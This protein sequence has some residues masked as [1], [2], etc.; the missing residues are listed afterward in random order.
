VLFRRKTFDTVFIFLF[1]TSIADATTYNCSYVS[2]PGTTAV[3]LNGINNAGIAVGFYDANGQHNGLMYDTGTGAITTIDY[4]GAFGTQLFS[5][6]SNNVIVGTWTNSNGTGFFT[7]N[8]GM[9]A[10]IPVRLRYV[11]LGVYGINDSG[12][13]SAAAYLADGSTI[14]PTYGIFSPDG[15]FSPV[16][17][18]HFGQAA[19]Q[20]PGGLNNSSEMLEVVQQFGSSALGKTTGIVAA[21]SYLNLPT[22]AYGLNNA[23]IVI[24]YN[25]TPFPYRDFTFDS[26]AGT[27]SELLC[28]ASG[29]GQQ[30]FYG[31][32]DSGVLV[33]A[34]VATPLPG[35]AQFS[36]STTSI[37]FPPT[38]VG[39]TSAPISVTITNTGDA[40]LDMEQSGG[41]ISLSNIFKTDTGC[42]PASG[43]TTSL[44]PGAS[45]T[46]N[47][48][49]TPSG[50]G[51]QTGTAIFYN[52]S[53]TP[54]T[55]NL[56]VTGTVPPPSCQVSST[57][58][59][60]ASLTMQDT[61]SG[62]SS[63]S[64]FSQSNAAVNIPSFA[65]GATSPVTA[66]ASQT[67]L[68]Q[69]GQVTLKAVNVAGGST[70]CSASFH[71]SSGPPSWTGLGGSVT[72]RIS[73]IGN[74]DGTLQ[75]FTR[76]ADNA[77][78]TVAQSSPD[79]PWGTWQNIGGVLTSAPA[80]AKNGHGLLE[81]FVAGSDN[82]LWE[83]SQSAPNGPFDKW[84]GLGQNLTS[85]PA[86]AA[87]ADGT[88]Q[89]FAAGSDHTLWT[90]HETS[91]GG[92]W[93]GW[94]SLG[95]AMLKSPAAITNTDGSVEA[96]VIGTDNTVWHIWQTSPGGAWSSWEGLG[97]SIA[98]SPIAV[99]NG[100]SG[101]VDVFAL[102]TDSAIWS[103]AHPSG[104]GW[105]GWTSLGGRL[106]ADPAAIFDADG[107][108]EVFGRG[109]DNGL[110]RTTGTGWSPLGGVLA[111]GP[112]AA[113]NQ[114][115]R[116]AVFVEGSDT[117]VWTI[118]QPSAGSWDQ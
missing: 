5:I 8:S 10:P 98:G 100:G 79:G 83:A 15:S 63:I 52:S 109:G 74:S 19:A 62:L 46:M 38:P 54:S 65:S 96:F 22:F 77:L 107:T 45:C 53:G 44:D 70:M 84:Q 93:A 118:E 28:P 80:V 105:S 26:N 56:S 66:T 89:V 51:Q 72:G 47:M 33:G 50:Q 81:V 14:L 64:L 75:A 104:A 59:G 113:I 117:T 35:Q 9:F 21:V 1:A 82:S 114:N 78:W 110:W 116:V 68:S 97:G 11:V 49:A 102:G 17:G 60:Q 71:S 42:L 86:V 37:T 3:Q 61:N 85:D 32:N 34:A 92:P 91:P 40:R 90:I 95:G 23:G 76:G 106:T 29:G 87:N 94:T 24:G 13:I 103:I 18:Y 73:V 20:V 12:A 7:W 25:G 2:I 115:G 88:I 36:V 101:L 48:T 111:N 6:S 58:P 112:A 39:A 57:G 67:N 30:A 99:L 31:I 108:N 41:T 55:L 69:P 43:G 4:P 16:P 27:Y